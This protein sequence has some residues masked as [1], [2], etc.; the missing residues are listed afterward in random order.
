MF[1][2]KRII[3]K[4]GVAFKVAEDFTLRYTNIAIAGLNY[5]FFIG[6]GGPQP[7]FYL[8]THVYSCLLIRNDLTIRWRGRYNEDTDLCLQALTSD[9][10]TVNFNQFMILKTQTMTMKGGNATELYQ[11]DGRLKM[12]KSLE[13]AWPYVVQTKRRYDR[14]QHVVKDNWRKFDQQL[15]RRTD[16][17]WAALEAAGSN[18]YG[19]N[20]TQVSAEIKSPRIKQMVDETSN[21]TKKNKKL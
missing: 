14:P 15:I 2:G 20:V 11:G 16:I 17:D 3:C 7:P 10:C 18:N 13:R 19:M 21:D 5:Y 4:S 12:A 8:N 9:W 1:K 6:R